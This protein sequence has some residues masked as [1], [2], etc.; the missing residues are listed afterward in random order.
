[1][2]ATEFK[3]PPA[4]LARLFRRGRPDVVHTHDQRSLF[5]AAIAA[6]LARV[7]RVVHTRH[8]RGTDD[9]LAT[10][11]RYVPWYVP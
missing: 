6:R 9:A 3:S 7:P 1:M 5:Y 2:I 10:V 4:R 8:G 11:V